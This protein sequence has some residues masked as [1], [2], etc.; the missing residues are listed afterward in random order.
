VAL[1]IVT[2]IL[3]AAVVGGGVVMISSAVRNLV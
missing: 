1:H 3:E 2:A